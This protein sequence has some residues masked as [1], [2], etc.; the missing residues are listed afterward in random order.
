MSPR[1][2]VFCIGY[3][4]TGT[5]TFDK[6]MRILGYDHLG[7]RPGLSRRVLEEGDTAEAFRLADA[8]ESFDDWPWCAIYPEMD[9]RYPDARFVL[10]VRKD[11]AAWFD[12]FRA[13]AARA[14]LAEAWRLKAANP[15]ACIAEYERHNRVARVRFAAR[16]EK[17]L[18]VCW[19]KGDGWKE[20]CGFLGTDVPDAPLPH[21][22]KRPDNAML[23]KARKTIRRCRN[24]IARRLRR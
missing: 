5:T 18:V 12:S 14:G 1:P 15:Q 17:L 3:S 10:T 11:S 21:A 24:G 22:N 13:H 2:K 19:E 4:K 20:L 23:W 6:C 16:P 9:R 7:F 8:H